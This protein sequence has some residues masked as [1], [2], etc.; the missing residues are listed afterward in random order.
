[1]DCMQLPQ[2]VPLKRFLLSKESLEETQPC[3][4][5]AR[6]NGVKKKKKV[7]KWIN[8]HRVIRRTNDL[9]ARPSNLHPAISEIQQASSLSKRETDILTMMV[10]KGIDLQHL[11][12]HIATVEL[13]HNANRLCKT[14]FSPTLYKKSRTWTST[15]LPGSRLLLL[16]ERPPRLLRGAEALA[17]Q[18]VPLPEVQRIAEEGDVKDRCPLA[19]CVFGGGRGCGWRGV[20]AGG[21]VVAIWFV[22]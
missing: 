15:L 20:V 11:H 14:L 8:T 6:Q 3:R 12:K 19:M 17:L 4:R 9:G 18:G 7:E 13:K 2:Q 5:A 22:K 10:Q 16:G 1:M 21:V